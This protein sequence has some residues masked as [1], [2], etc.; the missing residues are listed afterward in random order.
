ME[1][2]AG[3]TQL[4]GDLNDLQFPCDGDRG[5]ACLGTVG[6]GLAL[7][8]LRGRRVWVGLLFAVGWSFGSL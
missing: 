8:V 6:M 2:R 5:L 7:T 3:D 1:V 4:Q